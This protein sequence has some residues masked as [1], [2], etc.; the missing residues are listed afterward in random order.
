MLS[1]PEISS[2]LFVSDLWSYLGSFSARSHGPIAP[3]LSRLQ[4]ASFRTKR[5]LLT[6]GAVCRN[7]IGLG[8]SM[9]RSN[10]SIHRGRSGKFAGN[11]FDFPSL[12][13]CS[14]RRSPEERLVA[15]FWGQ[16]HHTRGHLATRHTSAVDLAIVM[17]QEFAVL[18]LVTCRFNLRSQGTRTTIFEA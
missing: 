8:S 17:R 10:F 14:A 11:Y 16:K 1:F 2:S 15:H 7:E 9:D 13:C 6:C 18:R 3:S 4:K 12:T 5:L